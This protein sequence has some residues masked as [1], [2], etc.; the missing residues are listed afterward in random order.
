MLNYL[1]AE[2]WRMFRRG[3]DKAGWL[4]FLVPAAL[5]ALLGTSDSP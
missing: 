4:A 3:A 2:L 5:A 1:S